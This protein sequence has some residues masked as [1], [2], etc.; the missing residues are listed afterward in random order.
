MII[1]ILSAPEIILDNLSELFKC[2]EST[3]ACF[4][5]T[6]QNLQ[7]G[8]QMWSVFGQTEPVQAECKY[9]YL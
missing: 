7:Q 1:C 4:S 3:Y 5:S 6:G 8:M 9:K 2:V